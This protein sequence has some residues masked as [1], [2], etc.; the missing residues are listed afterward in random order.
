MLV[1][2]NETPITPFTKLPV[3]GPTAR[4]LSTHVDVTLG[5]RQRNIEGTAA[6]GG[7]T[8]FSDRSQHRLHVRIRALVEITLIVYSRGR[9]FV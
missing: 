6:A 4:T 8:F 9:I 5:D 2:R 3:T 7:L 1:K